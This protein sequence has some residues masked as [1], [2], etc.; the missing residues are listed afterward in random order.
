MLVLSRK[1]EESVMVGRP[2]D[3][4]HMLKVTIVEIGTE[5][6]RLGFEADHSVRIHRTEVWERIQAG[7]PQTV[8]R[9]RRRVGA[10]RK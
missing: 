3:V 10:G 1:R 4:E 7:E 9:A 6:V 5:H 2:D 8:R